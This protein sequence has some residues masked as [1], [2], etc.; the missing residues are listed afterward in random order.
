MRSPEYWNKIW[1]RKY[2]RY[3]RHHQIIWDAIKPE[4]NI[5]DLGCGPAVMYEGKKVSLIGV[6]WSEEALKQAKLH[7]PWGVF[8]L[9]TAGNTGLPSNQ[10]DTVVM[11]GLLDYFDDWTELLIEARRLLKKN[12]RIV[13]TL[14]QGFNGHNWTEDTARQKANIKSFGHIAGGWYLIE[15]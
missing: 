13:A 9:A 2:E 11:L 7:Y 1:S 12:G 8:I 5:V 6:D 10:F 14:L 3:N 4:G 15:L